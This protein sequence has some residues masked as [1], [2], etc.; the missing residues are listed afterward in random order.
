[1]KL[2][3][4]SLLLLITSG[5]APLPIFLDLSNLSIIFTE[6]VYL[7][8][9][10]PEI[11]LPLSI[12]FFAI[13]LF[14]NLTKI[15]KKLSY[16]N[17][18][19]LFLLFSI[20]LFLTI[21]NDISILR[22]IQLYLPLVLI[23]SIPL[24]IDY[25]NKYV[26]YAYPI[27][28]SIFSF[29]HLTYYFT[30]INNV[31]CEYNCRHIFLGYE[32]YHAN[33]GFPEVVMFGLC[34]CLF[35]SQFK[36]NSVSKI[37]FLFLSILLLFYAVFIA[38]GASALIFAIATIL[39]LYKS[40]IKLILKAK[41]NKIVLF[42]ISII[43]LF[44]QKI[45]DL[46]GLL[47]SRISDIFSYSPRLVTWNYYL[48]ELVN[49]PLSLIFGGVSKSVVGHNSLLS[50]IT[51]FGLLGLFLLIVSYLIGLS[52]VRKYSN[53]KFKELSEIESYS[54]YLFLIAIVVGNFVNDS[55]TQP[56]N[57]I[58]GFMLI[59]IVLSLSKYKRLNLQKK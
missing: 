11:P 51:L 58:S 10:K 30:S 20:L 6:N 8:K 42:F 2:N 19:S 5:L 9:N 12:F 49:D 56:L 36:N 40:I 53:F 37:V 47:S 38:R 15:I 25:T 17:I 3:L 1:M 28:L 27:S 7:M 4:S 45:I 32:I 55:I 50:V 24:F 48:K 46:I 43:V 23:I 29:L 39:F 34:C 44:S 31:S 14:I 59:V 22:L 33:V 21:I 35:L 52:I 16:R 18:F 57:T 13:V 41:I 26:I 54:F